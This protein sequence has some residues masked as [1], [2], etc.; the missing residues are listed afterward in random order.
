MNRKNLEKRGGLRSGDDAAHAISEAVAS[1]V[2]AVL[3]DA[4]NTAKELGLARIDPGSVRKA[5]DARFGDDAFYVE[6]PYYRPSES[7]VEEKRMQKLREL[8]ED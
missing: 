8:Q 6:A 2:S 4:G 1:V 7:E 5:I 3:E